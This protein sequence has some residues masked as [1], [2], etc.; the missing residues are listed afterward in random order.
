VVGPLAD[1]RGRDRLVD[2][3]GRR[4]TYVRLSLTD[5][6]NLRCRYCRPDGAYER[7]DRDDLLDFDEIAR[8]ARILARVG[9]RRLRLTGGE[10]TLRRGICAIVQGIDRARRLG[11][12]DLA[13]TTNGVVLARLAPSLADAGLDRVNVSLDTLDPAKYAALTGVDALHR[14]LAGIDRAIACGLNPVKVNMVV[15]RGVNEDE[16][17]TMAEHFADRP[18]HLRFIEYMPFGASRYGLVPWAETRRRL[19]RRFVLR[20]TVPEGGGPSSCWQV[21]GAA[22]RVGAIGAMTRCFCASCN[23]IRIGADGRIRACLADQGAGWDL[24]SAL[25]H[26]DDDR[27]AVQVLRAAVAAKPLEHGRRAGGS[28]DAFE[29][30]MTRV[31]G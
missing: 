23:R 15:C 25:R 6:C 14:V 31:G 28:D 19:E 27:S 4:V 17:V 21:E 8:L 18:V 16:V 1:R 5:R 7:T 9:V 22:L 10:P 3:F 11:L 29:G 12:E 13:M 20:S 26:G 30:V 2:P 24:R